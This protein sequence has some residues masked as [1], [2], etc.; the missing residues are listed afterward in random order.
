[1]YRDDDSNTLWHGQSA[2]KIGNMG[3]DERAD[4]GWVVHI[5]VAV[6]Q[7][8]TGHGNSLKNDG[9][10]F[11]RNAYVTASICCMDGLTNRDSASFSGPHGFRNAVGA[12]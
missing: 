7:G 10:P 9:D 8:H 2:C 11:C 5:P 6:V 1:M 12:N 3:E 4:V